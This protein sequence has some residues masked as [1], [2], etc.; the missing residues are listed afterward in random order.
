MKFNLPDELIFFRNSRAVQHHSLLSLENKVVVLSGATSG[1]GLA[2]A[3]RFAQD[4]A[5][6]ILIVRNEQKGLNLKKELSEQYN[7]KI[8]VVIADFQ[9]FD[10]IQT[11]AQEILN[12]TD[13]IDVLI[14]N[15]GIH[16]ITLVQSPSGFDQVLTVN[17]LSTFL[18]T[19]LLYPALVNAKGKVI[20]VNSEGHRFA[21]FKPDDL[22]WKKRHYTGLRSYGA[23][24]TAQLLCV[25]AM[26]KQSE[27]DNVTIIAMHPGD[28]RSNIGKNN[29]WVYR[30]FSKFF[31]QPFLKKVDV[32]SNAL[33]YLSVDPLI[34]NNNGK[35]Y[36]LT[37]LEKPA[38]HA[39]DVAH[40][41]FV[42]QQSCTWVGLPTNELKK[43]R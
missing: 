42:Y 37:I 8:D 28:V 19:H 1:I 14:N 23:S 7:T 5:H 40:S 17:H 41:E 15:A 36:H 10:S 12:L 20:Y 39:I 13:T 34:K 29:G 11:A 43:T 3:R 26:A 9:K 16:S 35:F 4:M 24:K 27:V 22:M 30:T 33:H 6:L 25:L 21:S 38:P 2:T 32:A 31:I 18:L